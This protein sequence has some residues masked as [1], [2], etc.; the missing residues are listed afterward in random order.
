MN[1]NQQ[2]DIQKYLPHR[3]PMLMVDRIVE[4]NPEKVVTS[5]KI[6]RE[7]IFLQGGRLSE[8]GLIEHAAQT[9]SSIL[10]QQFF[11]ESDNKKVIGYITSIKQ[12]ELIKLPGQGDEV[13]SRASLIS[14]FGNIC[15]IYC[16]TFSNEELLLKTD[17]NLLIQ[18]V[19]VS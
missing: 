18:E 16:E 1:L 17:I 10:G 4:L 12:I 6:E 7:N 2:I 15:H 14:M 11:I 9:C 19:Q 3:V 8:T 5:F 13:I